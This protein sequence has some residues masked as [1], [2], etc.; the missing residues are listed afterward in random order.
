MAREVSIGPSMATP[1]PQN[2][3]RFTPA[4]VARATGGVLVRDGRPLAGV[5]TDTR[6]LAPG[7]LYV[8]LRGETFDGHRFLPQATAAG[9][10][11]VLISTAGDLPPN[12][13]VIRVPDTR[14]ALG[15]LA[16]FHR[17]RWASTD[18]RKVLA[19]GGSAGKT[20]TTRAVAALLDVLRPGEVQ[21]TPG[22]LNNDVGLPMT[23][24]LLDEHHH[25]AAVEVGTS[26]RGE[27]ARLARIA[28][29]DAALV[30]LI[31]PEHTE[32]IGTLEDVADEEGDLFAALGADGFAIGNGDD[33]RVAAQIARAPGERRIL[34]GFG[35]SCD[36]RA[37]AREVRGLDG[38]V[39]RVAREGAGAVA[40]E[41]PLAGEAG[42][43]A[44]LAALA[45]VRGLLGVDA[46]PEALREALL[47]V[48]SVKDGRFAPET[49][50]DGTVL[51]DDTYNSNTGSALSSLKTAREL[52]DALGRRLVLV[53]GEMRELGELAP[54]EHDVVAAAAVE[55]RPAAL[56]A[57]N[58]EAQRFARAA[59]AAGIPAAF[60]ATGE[61]AAPRV[62]E[63]VRPGDVV[64]V[65]ASRGVRLE[66][67]AAALR[68][69]R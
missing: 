3:A 55:A 34:Y 21:T 24:L 28:R 31:A 29:P 2:T 68:V 52:A 59:E 9:A 40:Y 66:T 32:G 54:A 41:V 56:V 63:A 49:L 57:V 35:E 27:I 53:L 60:F 37:L 46:P 38:S 7:A 58:G 25:L 47:R 51:L 4:E 5:S 45:A 1:I 22:N 65:K 61:A 6:T 48:A 44:A 16:R 30:T 64:L 14:V 13:A 8:A 62:V 67:V 11:G 26:H 36:V 10:G 39:L 15:D 23:L 33:P 69:A 20:T 19:V 12:G 43:Y 17:D 50:A 18:G 42:A